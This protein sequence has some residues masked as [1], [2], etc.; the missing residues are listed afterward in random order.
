MMTSQALQFVDFTKTQK[1]KYLKNETL[2]FLQIKKFIN[3]ASRVLYGKKYF[4]SMVTFKK[5][6]KTTHLLFSEAIRLNALMSFKDKSNRHLFK[7][8]R[9]EEYEIK[10]IKKLEQKLKFYELDKLDI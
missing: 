10:A 1:S 4:C 7:Y 5:H 8:K 3:Y 2:F 6:A 9:V